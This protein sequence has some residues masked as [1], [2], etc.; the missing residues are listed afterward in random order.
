MNY[1]MTASNPE[2]T[3]SVVFLPQLNN[4]HYIVSEMQQ[5]R[6]LGRCLPASATPACPRV[7]LFFWSKWSINPWYPDRHSTGQHSDTYYRVCVTGISKAD[8]GSVPG[9]RRFFQQHPR[10]VRYGL[11]D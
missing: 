8:S 11:G 3:G 6:R 10:S 5:A 7:L 9:A 1:T 4:A 2:N